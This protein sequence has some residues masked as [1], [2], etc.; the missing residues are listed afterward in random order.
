MAHSTAAAELTAVPADWLAP[1]ASVEPAPADTR[2]T[3]LLPGADEFFRL[4]YTR[5]GI[6]APETLAVCSAL[7]GEGKTT[8]ALGLGVTLAQDFPERRVAVVETDLSRPV[9]AADFGLEPAPG[10]AEYLLD[11]R[12]IQV[13]CRATGLDNLALVPAGEP[14]ASPG[15]LLRSSRMATAIEALRQRHDLVILDLPPILARSDA[16]LLADL[17]DGVILVVRAGL[18]PIA[19]ANR[20]IEQ[21]DPARL[22]GVVLNEARSATPGW[23]RRLVGL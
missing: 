12:P 16:R 13:V 15:R 20:A 3:W 22:R 18:T 11:G 21:F 14:S 2:P 17:A 5:A 23:L 4:I 8:L 10:L 1:G 7:A 19:L 6:G 9:L